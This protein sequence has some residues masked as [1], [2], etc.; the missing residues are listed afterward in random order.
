MQNC[1]QEPEVKIA[2]EV[3]GISHFMQFCFFLRCQRF[4]LSYSKVTL[5]TYADG[6]LH[7]NLKHF[8]NL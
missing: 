3:L 5:T 2:Q 8:N 6:Y 7:K 4:R 1:R